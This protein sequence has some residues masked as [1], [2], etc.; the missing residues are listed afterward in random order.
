[1]GR[2]PSRRALRALLWGTATINLRS[3]FVSIWRWVNSS[4]AVT[5]TEGGGRRRRCWMRSCVVNGREKGPDQRDQAG[6]DPPEQ[7]HVLAPAGPAGAIA[8]VGIEQRAQLD[9]DPNRQDQQHRGHERRDEI[10]FH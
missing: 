2:R 7:G 1:M 9:A 5:A 3:A 8:D 4:E 10:L 6:K